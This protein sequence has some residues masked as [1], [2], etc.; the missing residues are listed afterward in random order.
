[1]SLYNFLVSC[2]FKFF[3]CWSVNGASKVVKHLLLFR[4]SGEKPERSGFLLQHITGMWP[5]CDDHAFIPAY[6]CSLNELP[7]NKTV[8]DVDTVE[9]SGC[10]N[11][12]TSSKSCLCGSLEFLA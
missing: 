9:K 12:L 3:F 5:E 10:Y 4:K 11:H 1:M 7:Y 8:S 2:V 6:C